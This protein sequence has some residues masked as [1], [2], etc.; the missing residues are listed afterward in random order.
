M[1][2]LAKLKIGDF[3]LDP[4][5]N[6]LIGAQGEITLEAK[7]VDVLVALAAQPGAVLGRDE[8]I[9]AVW[10]TEFGADERLTRAI[11]MLRKAFHD[12]RGTT[13]YIET[14][15]KRGYELVARVEHVVE[16]N[17]TPAGE[18]TASAPSPAPANEATQPVPLRTWRAWQAYAAAGAVVALAVA[19]VA[20]LTA[21]WRDPDASAAV[22]AQDV[23]EL[24]ALHIIDNAPAMNAFARQVHASLKR[25]LASNQVAL[26]DSAEQQPR[27]ASNAALKDPEFTLSGLLEQ[28]DDQYAVTLYLDNRDDGQTLWSQRFTRSVSKGQ[29]LREEIGASAAS[30]IQCALKQRA[31][32]AVRPA[33]EVFKAYFEA[34]NPSCIGG[35]GPNLFAIAQRLTRLAPNDAY[36]HALSALANAESSEDFELTAAQSESYKTAARRAAARAREID[37]RNSL[38][39]LA[40]AWVASGAEGWRLQD[41]YTKQ[42]GLGHPLAAASQIGSLRSSGRLNEAVRVIERA[43]AVTP[44]LS[45]LKTYQ[46]VLMMSV[47]DHESAERLFGE[48][49]HVWPDFETAHWFR[50]VNAAF[51]SAPDQALKLLNDLNHS[52]EN[53]VCWRVFI[54][55]RGRGNNGDLAAVRKAC[56]GTDFSHQDY[57]ARMLA[58]LGDTDGAYEVM[59]NHSFDW[60]GS[61]IFLFYPEMTQFRRDARFMP[62]VLGSGLVEYWTTSGQWPDFCSDKDQTYDCKEAAAWAIQNKLSVRAGAATASQQ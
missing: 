38:A 49:L 5:R 3:V 1:A 37:P 18:A 29:G 36:G 48:T 39:P 7:V 53:K 52:A 55:A 35:D 6:L 51:Y 27:N 43:V 30:F 11:S 59:K 25:I 45:G 57:A 58:A 14:V 34:C 8:L 17:G 15:S 54:E 46:G 47:G 13:Q 33:T 20:G 62:F 19:G 12:E 21:V 32:A 31:A 16:T 41:A 42:W 44:L 28:I 26:V 61:T 9:D 22:N 60:N 10:K 40:E 4:S 50:F 24:G 2:T 56:T 23:V